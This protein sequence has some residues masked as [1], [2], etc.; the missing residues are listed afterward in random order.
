[1][2]KMLVTLAVICGLVGIVN[3]AEVNAAEVAGN[4]ITITA[5]VTYV[6]KYIWRGY[7][8]FGADSALQPSVDV[9]FGNGFSANVWMSYANG[10]GNVNGTEYD[11]TLA[12]AFSVA[13]DSAMK[14]D[15]SVG[16]RYYDYPKVNSTVADMQE[17][18]VE[19]AMPE[20]VGGGV[21]PRIAWYYMWEGIR[22]SALGGG[23]SGSIFDLG[24]DYAF[25]LEQAP[26]LPMTF[27]WDIV[28]NDGVL[29]GDHDWSHMVWGLTTAMDCPF[30][31][32]GTITPGVY[33][34]N[35]WEDT[36]NTSDELWA[37]LSYSLTF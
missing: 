9:D 1:M 24:I 19:T 34:Q 27:S 37:S 5:D 36:V 15:L 6:T 31:T 29:G 13:E 14:T 21:T 17:V 16:Y 12:Y 18:F 26:E 23:I 35:S 30:G 7:N 22:D 3:A 2:K 20:L 28:Y 33:F 8:L 11:Y 10:G 32:G 25:T 4:D